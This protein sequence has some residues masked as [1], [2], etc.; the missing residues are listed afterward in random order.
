MVV[1]DET[2]APLE[3]V[4]ADPEA[5]ALPLAATL[6]LEASAAAFASAAFLLAAFAV[7]R[8]VARV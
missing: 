2:D 1:L 7:A 4:E 3:L 5:D 8:A 6:G